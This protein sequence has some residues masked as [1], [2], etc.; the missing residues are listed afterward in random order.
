MAIVKL[1]GVGVTP[2]I[3]LS[4]ENGVLDVGDALVGDTISATLKVAQNCF[5]LPCVFLLLATFGLTFPSISNKS[6][7]R[8]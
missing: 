4:A 8:S 5:C 3:T 7:F 6:I 1:K 2:S